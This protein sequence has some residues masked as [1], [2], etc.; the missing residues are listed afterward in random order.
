MAGEGARA[1]AS[2]D[3]AGAGLRLLRR[4]RDLATRR[5]PLAPA[6]ALCLA[7]AVAGIVLPVARPSPA[8][9]S[10]EA[11]PLGALPAAAAAGEDL[12]AFLASRRWGISFAE[13]YP[14]ASPTAAA[15]GI[16]P[17][18]AA[19]GFVGVTMHG[20]AFRA[21][22]LVDGVVVRLT[23]GA[24]LPDGQTLVAV[25]ANTVAVRTPGGDERVL[26]LF[27]PVAT[28]ATLE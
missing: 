20:G 5:W 11:D 14:S 26:V 17:A 4:G 24:E 6:V 28:E 27:P 3:P 2:P 25:D 22:V 8:A 18:L 16:N 23:A 9:V 21:L 7:S 10:D 15:T 12:S 19:L 13:A 1:L